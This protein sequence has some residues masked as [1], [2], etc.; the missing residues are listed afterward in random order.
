[1]LSW[2][3]GDSFDFAVL[4]TSYLTGAG[5]DAYVIYGRAPAWV[6]LRDQTHM[7][8]PLLQ[9]MN[10]G[11][12]GRSSS[13]VS[14]NHLHHNPVGHSGHAA[15]HAAKSGLSSTVSRMMSNTSAS[16]D[17]EEDDMVM[18]KQRDDNRKPYEPKPRVDT[19]SK[20]LKVREAGR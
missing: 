2:G 16:G 20:Y 7:E 19:E 11:G 5:Y 15:G 17:G 14:S 18:T 13:S 9:A 3:A 12:H 1:M 8:C 6:T 4:L 10:D